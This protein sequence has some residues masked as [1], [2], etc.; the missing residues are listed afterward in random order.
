M[1]EGVVIYSINTL[2]HILFQVVFSI[3]NKD[4]VW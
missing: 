1:L 2:E 3:H 4:E